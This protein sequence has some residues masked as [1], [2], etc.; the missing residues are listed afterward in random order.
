MAFGGKES[1]S[2]VGSMQTYTLQEGEVRSYAEDP[3]V[4]LK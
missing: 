2:F 3:P 4:T 1:R